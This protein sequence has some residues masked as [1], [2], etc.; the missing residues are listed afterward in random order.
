ME[1]F[2]LESRT[3]WQQETSTFD[4]HSRLK[5]YFKSTLNIGSV[6]PF[7]LESAPVGHFQWIWVHWLKL[8]Y[9]KGP[10]RSMNSAFFLSLTLFKALV[11][12][13]VWQ[14]ERKHLKYLSD[15]L[16]GTS[17]KLLRPFFECWF[18][19]HYII[20]DGCPP[21]VWLWNIQKKKIKYG[22]HHWRW[23]ADGGSKIWILVSVEV[24]ISK[25]IP[26]VIKHTAFLYLKTI[27]W[28][29]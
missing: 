24:V 2:W 22:D 10:H 20:V 29:T 19:G 8:L 7:N 15:W 25:C 4:K 12:R 17:L 18:V 21:T 6:L 13:F 23:F 26:N 16:T 3:I 14:T 9:M 11:T 27:N 1:N 5:A 28:S